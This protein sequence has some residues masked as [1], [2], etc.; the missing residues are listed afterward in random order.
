MI[1][2]WTQGEN[3]NSPAAQPKGSNMTVFRLIDSGWDREIKQ[4]RS[5]NP[6]SLRIICPFIK[7]STLENILKAGNTDDI[8]IITRFDLNCFNQG[9]SDLESLEL[10]LDVGA[11]IRGIQGL[12]SK[13]FLFE[14][15]QAIVTSANVTNAAF[16]HNHEF[17]F[18]SNGSDIVG[19]CEQYFLDLW[20]KA[21]SN[22][23]PSALRKWAAMLKKHRKSK[24]GTSASNKLPD[25]GET[26]SQNSP[27]SHDGSSPSPSNNAFIK[28]MGSAARRADRSLT[29]NEM[30]A[31]SGLSWACTYPK[32]KPPRQVEDGDII[33]MAR[34]VQ[35]PDDIVIFGKAIGRKHR[36]EEDTATKAEIKKRKWKK[37][38]P[39]YV[40]VH[41]G[42]FLNTDLNQGISMSLMM[43]ELEADSFMSTQRNQE[44][45]S[46]NTDPTISY[47]RKSHMMLTSE[48]R[49][50]IEVRLNP[51][52]ERFGH[53]DYSGPEFV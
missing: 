38:W 14:K 13:M 31:E 37:D 8:R 16:F 18:L 50:W 45:R 15:S 52:L 29:I 44:K 22:L 12:H 48:A 35:N 3:S 20:R 10:A 53:V 26:V 43:K 27:F 21:G 46:G 2:P 36:D 11:K 9:V 1:M 51:R 5:T 4:A 23:K 42:Q 33:Y 17:G 7:A 24:G 25:F 30:V 6:G 49:N 40:R 39:R 34:L 41:D 47:L 28:F 32:S 19:A